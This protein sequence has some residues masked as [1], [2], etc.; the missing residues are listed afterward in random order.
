MPFNDF[1]PLDWKMG[2]LIGFIRRAITHTSHT[3]M[4]LIHHELEFIE[5]Q[6]AYSG[7]PHKLIG[8]KINT[9]LTK[10]LYPHTLPDNN[11]QDETPNCY[12]VLHLPFCGDDAFKT[13]NTMRKQIP[14]DHSRVSISTTATKIRDILPKL[15]TCSIETR[16][17]LIRNCVYKYACPCGKVYIGET[18]RRLAVRIK[19]H[20]KSGAIRDHV[21]EPSNNC[22]FDPGVF[23]VVASNLKGTNARKRCEA[24]YIRWYDRK[25]QTVNSQTY[26][27]ELIIW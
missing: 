19:E 12:T 15:N 6:F 18:K 2:T 1:G 10:M 13:A 8:E 27:R 5:S 22:I 14:A 3:H 23:S 9:T 21:N 24:L 20:E 7:Y 26:S 11:T 25:A 17:P 16:K 4:A